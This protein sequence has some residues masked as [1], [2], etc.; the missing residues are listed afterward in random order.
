MRTDGSK[1]R[2]PAGP[3]LRGYMWFVV[4]MFTVMALWFSYHAVL[5][6]RLKTAEQSWPTADATITG[7]AL[8]PSKGK[9]GPSWSPTWTYTYV[10]GSR[11]YVSESTALQHGYDSNWYDDKAAAERAAASRSAG[12]HV[13]AYYDPAAPE[14]SVLDR[15]TSNDGQWTTLVLSLFLLAAAACCAWILVQTKGNSRSLSFKLPAQKYRTWGG[16]SVDFLTVAILSSLFYRVW[17]KD[18]P[19]P[20]ALMLN[21]V[22]FSVHF[23]VFVLSVL[24]LAY[25]ATAYPFLVK[26]VEGNM[27]A[28]RSGQK[29]VMPLALIFVA[30]V[31]LMYILWGVLD[32]LLARLWQ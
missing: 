8:R 11:T 17:N 18:R 27:T 10:V 5:E 21:S 26:W 4:A 24:F 13:S 14:R 29:S 16:R 19:S 6:M 1:A 25:R 30:S 3:F 12:S 22:P 23:L 9:G 2:K 15:R 32:G 28:L 31:L 7:S 20:V